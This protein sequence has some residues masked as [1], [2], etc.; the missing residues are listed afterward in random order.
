MRELSTAIEYINLVYI[1]FDANCDE[2]NV[3]WRYGD[4]EQGCIG[5]KI[6]HNFYAS[7]YGLG[8]PKLPHY[9]LWG[10]DYR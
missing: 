5:I 7:D 10:A 9:L 2:I 8:S 4:A 3:I 1:N 6:D